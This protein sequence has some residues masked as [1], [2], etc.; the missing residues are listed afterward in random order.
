MWFW[1]WC[2]FQSSL[3]QWHSWVSHP[4]IQN[5][6]LWD[7][8]EFTDKHLQTLLIQY[9]IGHI[10]IKP[11][12]PNCFPTRLGS[13]VILEKPQQ[14][15]DIS[16]NLKGHIRWPRKC[17]S[18]KCKN[19]RLQDRRS[20]LASRQHIATVGHPAPP[21]GGAHWEAVQIGWKGW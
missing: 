11:T 4:W 5:Q 9:S 8:L 16:A 2:D 15:A 3:L 6:I 10:C 14:R 13:K 19:R 21:T 1:T 20:I 18:S 7:L 12:L 17:H